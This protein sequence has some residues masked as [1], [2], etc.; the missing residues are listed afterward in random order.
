MSKD[1]KR[2]ITETIDKAF[3]ESPERLI[4][5]NA[6]EIQHDICPH[7]KKR[8]SE[9]MEYTEDGGITWRHSTCKNLIS[10][11][12]T[13]LEKINDWLCPYVVEA[14][15]QRNEARQALGYAPLP[16]DEPGGQMAA[17]NTAGLATEVDYKIDK[18]SK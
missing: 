6:H 3:C 7:C 14:R 8:I 2:I 12:E 5:R 10:R 1:L 4:K 9:R 17:V 16:S 15:K 18:K 13:P 11:P